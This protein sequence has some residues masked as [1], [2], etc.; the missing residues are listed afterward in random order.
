MC[1][2][3]RKGVCKARIVGCVTKK[4]TSQGVVGTEPY[5][6]Y[7]LASFYWRWHNASTLLGIMSG[8]G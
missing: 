3:S 1:D 7:E 5:C 2:F 4:V 8:M 6:I